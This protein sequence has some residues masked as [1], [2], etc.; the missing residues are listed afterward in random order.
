MIDCHESCPLNTQLLPTSCGP[1]HRYRPGIERVCGSCIQFLYGPQKTTL[2]A[3]RSV[4]VASKGPM[5]LLEALRAL[6]AATGAPRRTPSQHG[7]C[8]HAESTYDKRPGKVDVSQAHHRNAS[9]LGSTMLQRVEVLTPAD[10][11]GCRD[12]HF[13]LY[14]VEYLKSELCSQVLAGANYNFLAKTSMAG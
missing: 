2:C 9:R 1:C 3:P 5:L 6:A 8:A 11:Y 4:L 14:F 10:V 7:Y 12:Q 13:R